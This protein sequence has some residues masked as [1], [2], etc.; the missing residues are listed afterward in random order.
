MSERRIVFGLSVPSASADL[1]ARAFA[2]TSMIGEHAGLRVDRFDAPSY[3]ALAAAVTEGKVD[4]AWLPPIA[5]VRLADAVTPIGSIL[6]NGQSAYESAL[7]VRSDAPIKTIDALRQSRAGW[8]DRWSAAGFVLPRVKLALLG[9]DPRTVFRTETFAGSHR[10]AMEA[11]A[12]GACDVAGTYCRSD[13]EGNVV[14]GAWSEVPGL[15]VRVLATFGA[16]PP[17]VIAVRT[18]FPDEDRE[19]ILAAL[20]AALLDGTTRAVFR[21]LFDGEQLLEG[22]GPG[23]DS[24]R[25]ALEMATAR[26]LFD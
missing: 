20:R 25:S 15:D 9:V 6:R 11:L 22:L 17:D 18:G 12:E 1:P 2:L 14:S 7:V 21:Q 8:V 24:L 5:Y 19:K 23:Y 13:G 26:G 4:V 3:E 10:A 16:I